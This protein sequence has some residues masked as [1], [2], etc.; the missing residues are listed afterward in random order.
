MLSSID[1]DYK[2]RTRIMGRSTQIKSHERFV[3]CYRR[4]EDQQDKT[5]GEIILKVVKATI[6]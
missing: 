3:L 6:M 2:V 4:M 1:K 5:S